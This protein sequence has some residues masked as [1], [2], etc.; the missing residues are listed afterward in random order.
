MASIVECQ[1]HLIDT[2]D[3]GAITEAVRQEHDDRAA[4]LL[5]QIAAFIIYLQSPLAK[6]N[7]E[8]IRQRRSARGKD[9][10]PGNPEPEEQ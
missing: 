7:A 6:K 8:R 3:R 9:A 2:V 4:D 10:R 1:N 5:K